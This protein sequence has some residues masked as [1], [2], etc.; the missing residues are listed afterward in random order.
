MQLTF[1]SFYKYIIFVLI[2]IAILSKAN[3]PLVKSD[4]VKISLISVILFI[5]IDGFL[6]ILKKE[7]GLKV[8]NKKLAVNISVNNPEQ[9]QHNLNDDETD[10]ELNLIIEDIV[11]MQEE[12]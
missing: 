3:M 10:E 5:L 12:K 8:D 6:Y 4:I 7:S 9:F 2:N 1:Y 11:E